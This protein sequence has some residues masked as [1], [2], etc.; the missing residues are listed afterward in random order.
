MSTPPPLPPASDWNVPSVRIA[1]LVLAAGNAAFWIYIF[2][3]VYA[4][5]NPE[6]D[7]FDMLPVMPFTAIFLALTLPAAAKAVGARGYGVALA[8][9]LGATALN[10][11]IFLA[12][13][14][15]Y[16]TATC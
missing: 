7:G 15:S 2:P 5:A 3:C 6:G 9:V 11:I 13:L 1:A 8:L 12:L 14:S 4:H 10:A 16:A